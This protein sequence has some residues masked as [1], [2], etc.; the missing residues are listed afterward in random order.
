MQT[1]ILSA[2]SRKGIIFVLIFTISVFSSIAVIFT[3][4]LSGLTLEEAI[5]SA[6]ENYPGY[7][8]RLYSKQKQLYEYRSTLSPY[9]PSLD[10]SIS[11]RKFYVE[12]EDYDITS[13]ELKLSYTIYDGGKRQ[14]QRLSSKALLNIAD[15][16]LRQGLVDL[17]SRI[18]LA[19]FNA[20][21]KREILTQRKTQLTYAQKNYEVARGRYELGVARLSDTL[22]ASV[23]LED[24]KAR[25]VEAEGELSKSLSELSSL[26]GISIKEDELE[27][28]LME[29]AYLPD[30]ST[31]IELAKKSPDVRKAEFQKD[32]S[33]SERK[34]SSA[35]FLPSIYIDATYTRNSGSRSGIYPDEE[36]TIG[37]RLTFNIFEL[38]KFF[39]LRSTYYSIRAAEEGLKEAMRTVE[40][41]ISKAYEDLLTALKRLEVAKEQ[42]RASQQNYEQAFGE[43]KV[44][45]G[46][47]LSLIQ[48]E[49]ILA[50][51]MESLINS[52]LNIWISLTTLERTAGIVGEEID[53]EKITS[54]GN[55][56]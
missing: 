51:A 2:L 16:E 54:G 56:Q 12:P 26:T 20:L 35:D 1:Q 40:L 53:L 19:F 23:R 43:Y 3:G 5:R 11:Q 28:E 55:G 9:L 47:I 49:S 10:L 36:K 50:D 48:A 24:A 34:F 46:D 29:P 52:K 30:K 37:A 42:V 44:G 4:E 18:K 33:I 6:I 32:L 39:K 13:L 17:A 45:K 15:E 38:R 22:Q 27:G 7:K 41:N 31:L 25:I 8:A 21:A 14:S